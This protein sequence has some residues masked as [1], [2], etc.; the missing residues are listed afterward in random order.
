MDAG[1]RGRR[2]AWTQKV[3][4][5]MLSMLKVAR[6]VEKNSSRGWMMK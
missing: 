1:A 5:R 6:V 2:D 3:I 4:Y